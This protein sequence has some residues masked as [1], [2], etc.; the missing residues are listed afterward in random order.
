MKIRSPCCSQNN[1]ACRK[2]EAA[3][4][5]GP[6]GTEG[7]EQ[8]SVPQDG[9]GARRRHPEI[10][11]NLDSHPKYCVENEHTMEIVGRT[12][13]GM[14]V[15]INYLFR[16]YYLCPSQNNGP[17]APSKSHP[18]PTRLVMGEGGWWRHPKIIHFAQKN[19]LKSR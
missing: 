1:T 16:I 15:F 18:H 17:D 3:L 8:R 5:T 10:L 13:C 9:E 12:T 7:A 6:V 19:G 14:Q 11:R 4:R 2:T